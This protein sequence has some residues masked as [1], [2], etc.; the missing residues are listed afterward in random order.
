MQP[1][2]GRKT[3]NF[4]VSELRFWKKLSLRTFKELQ[5]HKARN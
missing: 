2:S 5:L 3:R 1:F 4:S